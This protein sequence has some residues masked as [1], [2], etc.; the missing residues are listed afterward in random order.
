LSNMKDTALD[1]FQYTVSEL[2]IRN[3]SI[4]DGMTKLEDSDSRINRTISKAV[5]Q[6]GC[7]TIDAKKQEYPESMEF[8]NIKGAMSSHIK[9]KLCSSCRDLLEKDIGRHLF[10]LTS[11]CNTLDLNLYD[12][13]IKEL[14]RLR[15]LGKYSLR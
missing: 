6:C 11:I 12:I 13:I 8:D 1:S 3:K 5:T 9:G 15:L 7:I 4:L 2:L 14:E 10:Y